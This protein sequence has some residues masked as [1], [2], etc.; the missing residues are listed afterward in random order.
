MVGAESNMHH[1]FTLRSSAPTAEVELPEALRNN[2]VVL[3]APNASGGATKV[4]VM[5][6]SHVSKTQAEQVWR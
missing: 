3:D 6:V 5:G 2:V 1:G 4:Y